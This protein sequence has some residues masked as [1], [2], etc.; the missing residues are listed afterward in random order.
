MKRIT[1]LWRYLA[2]VVMLVGG[3][4]ATYA[5]TTL[6]DVEAIENGSDV[7]VTWVVTGPQLLWDV[8]RVEV[9]NQAGTTAS[10]FIDATTD[11]FVTDTDW[12]TQLPGVY[13]WFVA[14][15]LTGLISET[16]NTLEIDMFT[17]VDVTVTTEFGDAP[18]ATVTY[19]NTTEPG[20]GYDYTQTLDA[21]GLY[22]F[23]NVRKGT[24]DFEVVLDGYT[25][26]SGTVDFWAEPE[27]PT[28]AM[29]GMASP[30]VNL[31]A[32]SYEI[33]YGE[34]TDVVLNWESD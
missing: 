1:F 3:L 19:E 10:T 11:V 4:S 9:L 17:T 16:S 30:P 13:E 24:Y 21:T 5:Q 25:T 18:M 7:E 14:D 34:G 2:L 32:V 6:S 22:T 31:T 29:V 26:Q 15:N 33:Y 20:E 8:N 28:Y 23:T 27:T 12:S